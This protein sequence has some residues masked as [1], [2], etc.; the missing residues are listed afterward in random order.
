MGSKTHQEK[1][2]KG[3]SKE[4]PYTTTHKRTYEV[5]LGGILGEDSPQTG[6]PEVGGVE[7]LVR[8]EMNHGTE[9]RRVAF[10]R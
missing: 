5:P 10:L 7:S 1:G 2:R 3:S 6:R 8:S 9:T 4:H